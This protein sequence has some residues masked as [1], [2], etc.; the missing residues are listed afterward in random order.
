MRSTSNNN[1]FNFP[2]Y[3]ET[4]T[5]TT[6]SSAD[7][8]PIFDVN[9]GYRFMPQ[10]GVALGFSTFGSTGV[11]QGAGSIPNPVFFNRPA[12]VTISPVEA[13]RSERSTYLMLIGS[14]PVATKTDVSVFIGPSFTRVKQ[15]FIGSATVPVGTQ[16]VVTSMTTESGTAIGVI[17]GGDI[18]Y[19]FMPMVGVGAF[20]RFNGGSTDLDTLQDVKA[21]GFQIGVGA[22][23]R[24]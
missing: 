2:L 24:F 5:V 4:A 3:R 18:A 9:V 7:G 20:V 1:D 12:S 8:G 22:R 10:F 23:L 15:D 16:T 13:K 19:Q 14:M 6:I 21:G 17:V 11:V